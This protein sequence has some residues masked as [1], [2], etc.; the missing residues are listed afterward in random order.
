MSASSRHK[1]IV[2]EASGDP[3]PSQA[4]MQ[5]SGRTDRTKLRNQVLRPLSDDCLQDR[6][7]RLSGDGLTKL[8]YVNIFSSM[9]IKNPTGTRRA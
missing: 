3:Q 9:P 7:P 1:V 6:R 4:L 5:P 8:R 2:L